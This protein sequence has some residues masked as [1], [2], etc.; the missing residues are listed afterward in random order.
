MKNDMKL[1]MESWR[2]KNL[3]EQDTIQ[4]A[5][6]FVDMLK[7]L[8]II[9]NGETIGQGGLKIVMGLTGLAS[10][11]AAIDFLKQ[12]PAEIIDKIGD[13]M[14]IASD[15]WDVVA[16]A[17]SSG[18]ALANLTKLP[19]EESKKA[20]FLGILDINDNYLKILDNRLENKIINQLVTTFSQDRNEQLSALDINAKFA[21]AL[22]AVMGGEETLTGATAIRFDQTKKLN[23][24]Q[25]ARDRVKQNIPFMG[26]KDRD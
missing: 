7:V 19:D 1:I 15:V 26:D 3:Q 16:G 4:T 5:G 23:K 25:V 8:Q 21:E 13:V 9:K 6:D 20:G 14:G 24:K 11:E 10:S 17:D 2:K 12:N 22:K 18:E